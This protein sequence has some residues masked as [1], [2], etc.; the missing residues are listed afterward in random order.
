MN[1]DP[2]ALRYP[3]GN[4]E[5]PAPRSATKPP[6][7]SLDDTARTATSHRR[8]CWM[9][10]YLRTDPALVGAISANSCT[11]TVRA[12][13]DLDAGTAVRVQLDHPRP[14][15]AQRSHIHPPTME[16][17]IIDRRAKQLRSILNWPSP[18]L[19]LKQR[20]PRV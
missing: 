11:A 9:K 13:L 16:I 12:H 14:G 18:A 5:E 15:A 20:S 17:Q 2:A 4:P 8:T 19:Q 10:P 7:A 3:G 1:E 6:F